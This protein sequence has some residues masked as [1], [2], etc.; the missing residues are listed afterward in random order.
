MAS[1]DSFRKTVDQLLVRQLPVRIR[2]DRRTDADLDRTWTRKSV[3]A[4]P[5]VEGTVDAARLKSG[6]V[7]IGTSAAGL[8]DLRYTPINSALP[9]VEV[10]AQLLE[11]ILT[12][13]Y[14]QHPRWASNT[15]VSV[16][17]LFG[18]VM[19]VLVPMMRETYALLLSAALAGA[20]IGGSWYA[21]TA[22]GLLID[23]TAPVLAVVIM[24]LSLSYPKLLRRKVSR[25]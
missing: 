10:H 9:G 7:L 17:V 3:R 18:L 25:G 11:N 13:G 6:F 15:P 16:I 24:F 23:A 12:D 5:H 1:S 21:F 14:L 22:E 19:I 4:R 2:L 8:Y 20:V